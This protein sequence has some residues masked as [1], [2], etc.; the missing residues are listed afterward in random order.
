MRRY[1]FFT[2][3]DPRDANKVRYIGSTTENL[4]VRL[5]KM[6][7]E[8]L[9]TEKSTLVFDWIRELF[10][11]SL[12]P[13]INLIEVSEPI[14]ESQAN[15][16][17]AQLIEEHQEKGDCDLNMTKGRGTQSYSYEHKEETKE[18]IKESMQMEL[19]LEKI[20]DMRMKRV[21]WKKIAKELNIAYMTAYSRKD[22]VEAIIEAR[23]R[24]D[25]SL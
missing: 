9:K 4:N 25:E 23:G 5:S 10:D 19:D 20:A 6:I 24:S 17:Q 13:L 14:A 11:L 1:Y 12:R 15:D 16:R 2:L 18:K 21:S 7:S 8:S 22:E 3:T